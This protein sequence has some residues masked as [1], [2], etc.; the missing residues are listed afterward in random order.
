MRLRRSEFPGAGAMR[1]LLPL[2]LSMSLSSCLSYKEVEL[3]D[4]TDIR[5]ERLDARGVAVRVNALVNNPN[6]YRIHA[7]EP[8]VDLYLNDK[9]IGKGVLDSVITLLPKTTQVYSIPMHAELQGGSLLMVLLSGAL[10]GNEVK[11]AA[12]GTVVGRVGLFRKRFPFE[13]EETIDP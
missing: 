8:D 5:V 13:F 1:R 2:L 3:I 9:F 11:L 4:V 10:G 6:N 12:K 7:Q